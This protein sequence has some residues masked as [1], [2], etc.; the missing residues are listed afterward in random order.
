[1]FVENKVIIFV[2]YLNWTPQNMLWF[3]TNI[4]LKNAFWFKKYGMQDFLWVYALAVDELRLCLLL[5]FTDIGS[6]WCGCRALLS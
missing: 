5:L 1:M 4:Y 3:N 2:L 6:L